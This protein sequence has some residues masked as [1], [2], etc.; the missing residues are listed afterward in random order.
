[1]AC[2]DGRG[3]IKSVLARN[4]LDFY[5]ID[6]KNIFLAGVSAG[7]QVALNIAY[8][9][10]QSMNDEV[11][12]DV[13][14]ALG[15]IDID[16]YSGSPAITYSIKGVLNLWGAAFLPSQ[17]QVA[18]F[19]N[20][21]RIIPPMIAFQGL[22]DSTLYPTT[23]KVLLDHS[24]SFNFETRC[25]LPLNGRSQTYYLPRHVK[26]LTQSGSSGLYDVLTTGLNTPVP[27]ELY[28]DSDMAH[29][30]GAK[31]D[32]GFGQINK[33]ELR[34]YIVQRAATFFQAIANNKTGLLI[35]TKFTD[36]INSRALSCKATDFK[37]KNC[38]SN[39][40]ETASSEET[41][42]ISSAAM[43]FCKILQH[44]KDIKLQFQ[45]FGPSDIS[46][47]NLQGARVKFIHATSSEVVLKCTDIQAGIYVIIIKQGNKI[48]KNKI[49][50]F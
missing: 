2:Q 36:C 49:I 47:Y 27:C 17:I 9:T 20:Q 46:I 5:K 38:N 44:N 48:Q 43:G 34:K 41:N 32:F 19:L 42:S 11:F 4:N 12:L 31:S 33:T 28:L 25:L 26:T 6:E 39:T 13:A 10:T 16:Y 8:V 22:A 15:P 1:R 21:N 23:A 37:D 14:P 24:S 3:A 50:L 40:T 29:G 45:S 18:A 30:I 7:A 35:T